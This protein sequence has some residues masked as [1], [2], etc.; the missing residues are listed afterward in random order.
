MANLNIFCFVGPTGSGKSHHAERLAAKTEGSI[1]YQPGKILRSVVGDF[2][3]MVEGS[4]NPNA[5]ECA[6]TAVAG[7]FGVAVTA[8]VLRAIKNGEGLV[9]CDGV[10]RTGRQAA[11]AARYLQEVANTPTVRAG[12]MKI[13]FRV[14]ALPIRAESLQGVEYEVERH[15]ASIV[16]SAETCRMV[17]EI[18]SVPGLNFDVSIATVGSHENAANLDKAFRKMGIEWNRGVLVMEAS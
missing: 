13:F 17:A 3:A 16:D 15:A 4:P 11:T 9:V 2:K 14:V 10:P 12:G 5:W 18:G 6:E 1:L 8:G 7:L